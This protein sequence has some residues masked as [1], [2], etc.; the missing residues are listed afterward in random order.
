MLG[1]LHGQ[2]AAESDEGGSATRHSHHSCYPQR[3]WYRAHSRKVRANG[4]RSVAVIPPTP[5][6][7][8]WP[9]FASASRSRSADSFVQCIVVPAS[10]A[11]TS[12]VTDLR[13][14]Q[15]LAVRAVDFSTGDC[16][17]PRTGPA[18]RNRPVR[19]PMRPATGNHCSS[20][21][22]A[23]DARRIANEI[24][25]VG[26]TSLCRSASGPIS[27]ALHT[28]INLGVWAVMRRVE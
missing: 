2:T 5:S 6:A 22:D 13:G 27:G 19:E 18:Q 10:D 12:D 17:E 15:R 16:R 3:H 8:F 26:C 1:P 23:E 7:A 24:P 4:V 20:G 25:A 14:A 9:G 28:D 11:Y 21:A